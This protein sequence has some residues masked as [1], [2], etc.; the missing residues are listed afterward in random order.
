[1]TPQDVASII[2]DSN[3]EVK[4]EVESC[5]R[6]CFPNGN[7][8]RAGAKIVEDLTQEADIVLGIKEPPV[9][10]VQ[11]TN[12]RGGKKKTWMV[13]SHTHKGQVSPASLQ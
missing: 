9:N 3:G 2:R 5:L 8:E 13:F 10:E 11:A 7:Y 6:R 4:V 12:E 1:M